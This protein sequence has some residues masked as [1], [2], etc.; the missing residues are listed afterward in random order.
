[1]GA[2]NPEIK[3]F[4]SISTLMRYLS[5]PA[6][7]HPLFALIDY[8]QTSQQQTESKQKLSI[9]FY[10]ISF[11]D[12]FSGKIK[13]GQDYYDFEEGGLAFLKPGQIV[14][15]YNNLESYEGYALYFHP[16]FIRTYPLGTSIDKY[17]FFSYNVSEA[18]YLS[19]KEKAIIEQLFQTMSAELNENIDQFSQDVL[20]SQLEL[21]LNYSKRFYN[22][23]FITRKAVNHKVIDSLDQILKDYFQ[24]KKGLDTGLPSVAFISD[25]L[26]LSQR[27]LSDLLKMLIGKNA[28]QYIQYL[29]IEEAKELLSISSLSVAEVAYQLGFEHPQ[30]FSKLFKSKT[31][32]TP[33]AFRA[34]FN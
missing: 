5:L 1:M 24:Q 25:Q 16:D 34:S 7:Q 13:Y 20:V 14:T 15:P 29:V 3:H 32:M 27:Y 11:K 10:K 30:S 23:Q 28:Q 33:L 17:G 12:K 6:P 18:L 26:G 8:N 21:L 22:R 31:Q 9:D 4:K 2:S 19:A